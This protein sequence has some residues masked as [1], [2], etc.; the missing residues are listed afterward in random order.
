LG[1]FRSFMWALTGNY[2]TLLSEH[3]SIGISA[4]LFHQ[5][6]TDKAVANERGK[7]QSTDFAFDLGYMLRRDRY[8][9]GAMIQNI[10]P[11]ITFIDDD[12]SD[13]APTNM[14]LGVDVTV[15]DDGFNRINLLA[16][17]NKLLVAAYPAMDW[18]DD[19]IIGGYDK[20]GNGSDG[21]KYNR[22][23]DIEQAHTDSWWKALVTAWLDDWYLG[24]DL[25][26]DANDII[27]GYVFRDCG[28]DGLCPG[29]AGYIGPDENGT[30][31]DGMTIID[32]AGTIPDEYPEL[33]YE[34][35]DSKAKYN[36]FAEI[37]KGSES[38]RKFSTEFKEMVYNFGIEYWYQSYFALRAGY[39]YDQEGKITNPTFGAGV[40][41]DRYGFD[42]G[43][44]AGEQGHPRANTMF[45]SIN[46][47]I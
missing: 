8:S 26:K 6:L 12:Q 32:N 24:G 16:D 10:G 40:H 13:P 23:G 15:F 31:G 7:G 2:S 30:E 22:D 36:E 46:I 4:K 41:F 25:D 17:A 35:N 18:D 21:G 3:S 5:K 37:E 39:I 38:E 20:D 28:E 44:T 45:F 47:D 42:F 34:P 43:Y 11:K 9:I 27:G 33:F 1:T 14:K 29:D 19:G